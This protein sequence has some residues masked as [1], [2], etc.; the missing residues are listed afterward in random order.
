MSAAMPPNG[1]YALLDSR[2]A[3]PGQ[4]DAAA[5]A[6]AVGGAVLLQY[7]DKL[8]RP[9]ATAQAV[10]RAAQIET[11]CPVLINDD[12]ELALDSGAAGVHL[13]QSDASLKQ[14]RQRLGREAII[15]ITCHASL[16]LARRALANGADYVSFGRFFAS[17]T[18]PGAPGVDSSIL[19][20]ARQAG[21]APLVAIGGITLDNG[22]ELVAAGADYL[23]V[24]GAIFGQQDIA[25]ASAA[26]A[27]LFAHRQ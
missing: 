18:K 1:L 22:A 10:V 15:G 3:A 5:R 13:G 17:K 26:F 19:E 23:A 11:G 16:D 12:V 6:A 14:A 24:S 20:Q 7:R 4:E 8:G 9:A 27:R 2:W 25:G 21:L